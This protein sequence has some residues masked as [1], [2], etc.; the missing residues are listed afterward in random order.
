MAGCRN[1]YSPRPA[2]CRAG[3]SLKDAVVEMLWRVQPSGSGCVKSFRASRCSYQLERIRRLSAGGS[4]GDLPQNHSVM[5][6]VSRMLCS[7]GL[8]RAASCLIFT[9]P[10]QPIHDHEGRSLGV[11]FC[12]AG[13]ADEVH[14]W[15]FV[16]FQYGSHPKLCSKNISGSPYRKPPINERLMVEKSPE[17]AG[18]A[19]SSYVRVLRLY[20]PMESDSEPRSG[21]PAIIVRRHGLMYASTSVLSVSSSCQILHW[22]CQ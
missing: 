14:R 5:G 17:M 12:A 6:K 4:S 9:C 22:H 11:S 1:T 13:R 7:L 19:S 15:R 10:C 2:G 21:K 20:S 8:I 3:S 18:S 16:W